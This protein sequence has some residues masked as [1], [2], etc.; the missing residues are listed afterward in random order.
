VPGTGS[1]PFI[2]VANKL[3]VSGAGIGFSPGLFQGLSM[4]QVADDLSNPSSP[5]TVAV[6]GA[7]NKLSAAICAATGGRP[8]SV[9][10]SPGVRAGA[11][12]LGIG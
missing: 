2:D 6:L 9:C 7:A 3:V 4:T 10:T 1:L 11:N 12:R 5:E 8:V